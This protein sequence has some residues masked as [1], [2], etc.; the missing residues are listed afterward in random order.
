MGGNDN[1]AN[2]AYTE[3]WD[4]SSWTEVS[5]LNA[6]RYGVGGSGT[7]TDGL[8]FGAHPGGTPPG[9]Q[10]EHW[11]GT[12]W[13]EINDLSTARG[14]TSGTGATSS[15]AICLSGTPSSNYQISEEFTAT[16]GNKTITAS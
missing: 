5:D 9:T 7:S 14:Y 6:A 15:A 8:C 13:T 4:G 2:R 10:T 3:I 11:N 12:S 16:L 1:S